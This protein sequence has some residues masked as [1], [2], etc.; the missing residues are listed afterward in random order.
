MSQ[1]NKIKTNEYELEKNKKCLS[2]NNRMSLDIFGENYSIFNNK[3][4]KSYKTLIR[5]SEKK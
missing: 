2:D 4:N 3:K 1:T 5:L